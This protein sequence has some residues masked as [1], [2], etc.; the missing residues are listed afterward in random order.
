MNPAYFEII[1]M[2]LLGY[3]V[4]LLTEILRV[5]RAICGESVDIRKKAYDIRNILDSK[6]KS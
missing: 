4:Y 1:K 2:A 3:G 6:L 5:V